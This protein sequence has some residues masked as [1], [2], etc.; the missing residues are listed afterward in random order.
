MARDAVILKETGRRVQF[1]RNEQ[2]RV[3]MDDEYN[4]WFP[5]LL[6]MI[7]LEQ[8]FSSH[9]DNG[10]PLLIRRSLYHRDMLSVPSAYPSRP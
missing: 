9:S 7:M 10:S 6:C 1:W 2:G 3:Q 8:K 5:E 4:I